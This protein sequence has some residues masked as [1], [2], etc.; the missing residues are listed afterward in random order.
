MA[1]IKEINEIKKYINEVDIVSF[2]I[3]DTL[4]L[5]NVI[6]PTDIFKI[7]ERA[8]F[9][10]TN[11]RINFYNIR[12]KAEED[13]RSRTKDEDI[14]L[15]DIY[16]YIESKL[17][18]IA[19]E[20]KELEIEVEKKFLIANECMKE[21]YDLAKRL[22]K[23]IYIISDMYL[24][25]NIIEDILHSKGF[26]E[27]DR[28]FM[29]SELKFTK[30]TGSI[31]RYIREV[32][33]IDHNMQWVHIGDNYHSDVRNAKLN[34]VHGLY[35]KKLVER[36]NID[37]V[38]TIGESIVRAIQINNKYLKND[39]DYWY[40]FGANIISP[41]YIGLMNWLRELISEKD[42]IYFLARDGYIPYKL[43][44]IMKGYY[45]NIPEAK[46]L[47]ASRRAYIYPYLLQVNQNQALE[48][49]TAYN[50]GLGQK[51]TIKEILDN[52]GLEAAKYEEIL[53]KFNINSL[54][55]IVD[56]ETIDNTKEFLRYI[57]NDI[58]EVLTKELKSLK[59]YLKETE[60]YNYDTI[61][62]FD[63]GWRGSTHVA[64][65]EMV[66]K[67][68]DGYYFGTVENIYSEIKLNAYGYAFNKGAPF[69]NRR[70]IIDNV[71]M[72]ELI[73]SAPEGSLINFSYD[74]CGK[75]VPNFKNVEQ[76]EYIYECIEKFQKGAT[77]IFVQALEYREYIDDISKEFS[78][79]KMKK[80]I[81]SYNAND[82]LEFSRL[83]N[84]VGFGNSR[85]IKD[86][87]SIIDSDEYLSARN[88]YINKSKYNL[89]KNAIVIKDEQGRYFNRYEMDKL[90]NLSNKVQKELINKYFILAKKA[91]RN[92]KKAIIKICQI[93]RIAMTS[94]LNNKNA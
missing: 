14:L 60:I 82:M 57:W 33:Q 6:K 46:Y 88:K 81:N 41:I 70:F 22:N 76:N 49:L 55:E 56:E 54:N 90:N 28:L 73:F 16:I 74:G 2:D 53:C 1:S 43:Y 21:I 12:I 25:S 78:L 61:N 92:P 86:Y 3:F 11:T 45:D 30:A 69:K 71:M 19:N 39:K 47:Y 63:I 52:I 75:I 31:Y 91:I 37:N 84:S 72:Y 9:N 35:Y 10:R 83:S 7:V 67:Q 36:E 24:T 13:A 48:T 34:G 23:K 65:K 50:A 38:N 93:I 32:E 51:I 42:N 15:N 79:G 4:L 85:D 17:G 20:L 58:S 94:R 5:R 59:A 62:I 66:G 87:V 40:E 29:S 8:Y 77:D 26:N 64:I 89:W 68:V 27:Y 80:F 18:S 44:D